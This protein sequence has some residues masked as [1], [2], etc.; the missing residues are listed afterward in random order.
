L[1][2]TVAAGSLTAWAGLIAWDVVA[3]GVPLRQTSRM[4]SD[5]SYKLYVRDDTNEQVDLLIG[6]RRQPMHVTPGRTKLV[7]ELSDYTD[8]FPVRI[9][10]HDSLRVT[11]FP[12]K[13]YTGAYPTKHV[14]VR[15]SDTKPGKC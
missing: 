8:S 7:D 13:F 12:V 14:T 6:F 4:F 11:C 15:V 3:G 1:V 9:T 5:N 2:A 10:T